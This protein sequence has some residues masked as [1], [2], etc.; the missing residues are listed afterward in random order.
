MEER[1]DLV[2]WK[3]DDYSSTTTDENNV[4]TYNWLNDFETRYPDTDPPY[5]DPAQLQEFSTWM[6]SVDPGQAT[7]AALPQPVVYNDVTYTSDT[8]NYRKA[9]FRAELSRYVEVDSALFFYLFTE[10]FLM[11]DNRAKN[12][13][14]S[15]IGTQIDL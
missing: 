12:M 5:E 10:L 1:S 6:V 14:P 13:F 8:A 3:S 4:T 9:K 11:A 15:F 7:N 2:L